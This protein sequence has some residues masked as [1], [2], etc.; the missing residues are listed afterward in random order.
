M[1]TASADIGAALGPDALA[2]MRRYGLVSQ[3][4]FEQALT[5]SPRWSYDYA[6]STLK[7]RFLAGEPQIVKSPIVAFYYARAVLQTKWPE[8]YSAE[9]EKVIRRLPED[10]RRQYAALPDPEPVAAKKTSSAALPIR[11]P[12]VLLKTLHRYGFITQRI[13]SACASNASVAAT[14]MSQ[15]V[16]SGTRWP[17]AEPAI[18]QSP[19]HAEVY[20]RV[21]IKGRWPEAEPTLAESASSSYDY[22]LSVLEGPFPAGEP[23]IARDA[24]YGFLYAFRVL[25]LDRDAAKDWGKN[26]LVGHTAQAR[27]SSAALSNL[28]LPTMEA[29]NRYGMVSKRVLNSLAATPIWAY[30]YARDVIKRR[31]PEGETHI[32]RDPRLATAYARDVIKGR[33]PEAEA[34]IA[35][36]PVEAFVYANSL[37]HDSWPEAEPA[38]AAVP[39]LATHYALNVIEA[40]FPAGEPTIARDPKW[41]FYYARDVIQDRWTPGEQAIAT[42][43]EWAAQYA[44]EVIRGRWPEAEAIIAKDMTWNRKYQQSALPA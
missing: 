39:S 38:I 15:F 32:G 4:R 8:P 9:A 16:P 20:A 3:K 41:A 31:F 26:Y 29:L 21:A 6:F 17:E 2:A 42:M 1:R 35:R 33:W 37:I 40:R 36:D 11:S 5:R 18:A 34:G 23:A 10:R 43:P 12:Y 19:R 27:T 22:A 30:R 25:D 44:I 28:G 7:G 24:E 13:K 14:Y